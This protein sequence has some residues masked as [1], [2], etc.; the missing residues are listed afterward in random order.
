V[1]TNLLEG[2]VLV[3]VVLLLMLG[4]C[5]RGAAHRTVIPLSMLI[6]ITGMVATKSAP[7]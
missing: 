7:T 4:N 1:Q 6:L 5:A 3:I 2:A